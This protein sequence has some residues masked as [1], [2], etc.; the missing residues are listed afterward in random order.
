MAGRDRPQG[1]LIGWISS[2]TRDAILLLG[3]DHALRFASDACRKTLGAA[4]NA[5]DLSGLLDEIHPDDRARIE[6]ALAP[7]AEPSSRVRLRVR[8]GEQ[9]WR[10]V[11]AR[12]EHGPAGASARFLDVVQGVPAPGDARSPLE[13]IASHLEDVLWLVDPQR[14]L[15]LY[16]SEAFEVMFG[17]S[18]ETLQAGPR[19][20]WDAVHPE[21]REELRK[22][23]IDGLESGWAHEFRVILPDGSS[24]WVRQRSVPVRVAGS[25][26]PLGVGITQDI[27]ERRRAEEARRE[28]EQR[29]EVLTRS[30][31]DVLSEL[32]ARGRTLWS[33]RRTQSP[34]FAGPD[35]ATGAPRTDLVHEEDRAEVTSTFASAFERGEQAICEY[36]AVDD[37]GGWNWIETSITPFVTESG[38]RRALFV[39]RDVSKRRALV[40][41]LADSEERFRLLAE[42]SHELI[43]EYD[44]NARLLYANRQVLDLEGA[45]LEECAMRSPF[46][47]VHPEDRPRVEAQLANLAVSPEPIALTFRRQYRDGSWRW[48]EA[49]MHIHQTA[50][51]EP[52]MVCIARDVT[53][54]KQAE[55]RIRQSEERYRLLVERSPEAIVV[56]SDGRLLYAN[57]AALELA[58]AASPE[59]VLGRPIAEWI[60]ASSSRQDRVPGAGDEQAHH[61]VRRPDGAVREVLGS[62][63]RITYAGKPAVQTVLRDITEWRRSERERQQ[64]QV[65]LQEARKLESLGVLAGGIAHDFNNLLAVILGNT[66]YSLQRTGDPGQAREA[67]EALGDAIEAAESAARLTRQLLAYAGRRAPEVRPVDL[68][69]HVR[70]VSGLLEA[71]VPKKVRLQLHLAESLPLV[72]AD[73]VQL[74]QVAMNLVRNGA[75]AIGEEGGRVDVTTR[76]VNA[77]A[78][79]LQ[80]WTGSDEL[81][82]GEY[83]VLE[84]S[85]TGCGMTAETRQRIFDPFF[86]TKTDGHG[87]GLS[88]VLG[89]VRGHDGGIAIESVPGRGTSIRVLLPASDDQVGDL[90][91]APADTGPLGATVLVVDDEDAVRRMLHR[92][93]ASH[94]CRV[95][96]ARDGLEAMACVRARSAEIDIVLLDL[97]MPRADGEETLTGIRRL[98]PELPVLLSS[99]EDHTGVAERADGDPR[100]GFLAK[101]YRDEDLVSRL[102]SL[103]R[104]AG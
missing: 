75:D 38:E 8:S 68:S 49:H 47:G 87:L 23:A 62:D 34:T 29:F 30:A 88:A 82:P 63:S 59:T 33:S 85:D 37:R 51:G 40:Q 94:G 61:R 25:P 31:F 3:A 70:A 89:L 46:E 73:V 67:R 41:A 104:V 66:R 19:A 93:L 101:P 10:S 12:V 53:E 24:R 71:A 98:A 102:E 78:R 5:S 16:V 84:V 55:D 45:S 54:R 90:E 97:N 50:A 99:G 14:Q 96:E 43:A 20:F 83:V 57:P 81:A 18:R 15:L 58:G 74:E 60:E 86:T 42:H 21:D 52:R 39:T 91:R 26:H 35:R 103:L 64:L 27:D 92:T 7:G 48:L 22:V 9:G 1:D 65:Q 13:L 69:E 77:S 72:R 100:T 95:I 28:S 80:A 4:E 36:R 11:E 76:L 2:E 56:H 44:Q 32:D 79:D 17:R 6:S